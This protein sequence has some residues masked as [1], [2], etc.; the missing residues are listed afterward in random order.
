MS[1]HEK[2]TLKINLNKLKSEFDALKNNTSS[3]ISFSYN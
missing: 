3:V 1:E 2:A